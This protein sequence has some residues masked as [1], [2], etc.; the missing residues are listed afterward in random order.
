[1]E[2]HKRQASSCSCNYW[3]TYLLITNIL[4]ENFCSSAHAH[5]I[6]SIDISRIQCLEASPFIFPV[7]CCCVYR[8]NEAHI[9]GTRK[10]AYVHRCCVYLFVAS[11]SPCSWFPS[12]LEASHFFGCWFLSNHRLSS[13]WFFNQAAKINRLSIWRLFIST[14]ISENLRMD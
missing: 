7:R 9:P 5:S 11:I 13:N 2:S 12:T 10:I 4:F 6:S 8:I 14:H 1:M 3:T